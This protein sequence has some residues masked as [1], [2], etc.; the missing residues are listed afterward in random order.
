MRILFIDFYIEN[1][2]VQALSAF[3]KQRGHEVSLI[4]LGNTNLEST[5][6]F[7]GHSQVIDLIRRDR[8]DIVGFSVFTDAFQATVGLAKRLKTA[9]PGL[10]VVCGG[11][12]ATLDPE[13][14]LDEGC[15]DY[16]VV[17]EGEH[18]LSELL[19]SLN[20]G[21]PSLR[22]IQNLAY[23]DQEGR[24]VRNGVRPLTQDLDS[25]P[26]PDKDLYPE[27]NK[28]LYLI[29]TGRG[30]PRRCLYCVNSA[31]N[32]LYAGDRIVRRR[33]ADHVLA[34][35]RRAKDSIRRICFMDEM[36]TSSRVWLKEFCG[37]YKAEIGRPFMCQTYPSLLDEEI[38]AM[39][40]DAGLY[41]IHFG[42]QTANESFRTR[43]LRRSYSNGEL[44]A[45][46]DLLHKHSLAFVVDHM[47][48]LPFETP[49]DQEDAIA[50]Y[51]RMMPTR[52]LVF[53]TTV[54]PNTGL[55]R[56]LREH[57]LINDADVELIRRGQYS[58]N[59]FFGGGLR[60]A[61]R[62]RYRYYVRIAIALNLIPIVGRTLAQAMSGTR[63][64]R[65]FPASM[66]LLRLLF[67][68]NYPREWLR[69]N[70]MKLMTRSRQP[71]KVH[72]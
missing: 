21:A 39:L 20:G 12:H 32:M 23:R 45:L 27:V 17:G 9:C 36:F 40:K 14:L 22:S 66:N 2:G 68:V 42:V 58:S 46:A 26:V 28:R 15:I 59:Y 72:D 31:I 34:E 24:L 47:L 50:L 57:R 71:A 30:C 33:S 4:Q 13:S 51:A 65:F 6:T 19:D 63:I 69:Y 53:F 37:R 67:I 7:S 43:V 18:A 5:V 3:L 16:V 38:V 60:R 11:V 44:I 49:K 52:L 1:L 10:A 54:Y 62:V 55:Q 70:L 41:T 35:L 8:I 64:F 61:D 56:L 48:A 29:S 25:L